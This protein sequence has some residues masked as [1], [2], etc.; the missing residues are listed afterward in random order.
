[1]H[2][3]AFILRKKTCVLRPAGAEEFNWEQRITNLVN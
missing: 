1:M 3:C 2:T